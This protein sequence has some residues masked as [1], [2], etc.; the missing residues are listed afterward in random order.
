M[1]LLFAIAA[2]LHGAD[3]IYFGGT[4]L[5]MDAAARTAQ[6]VAVTNGKIEAVGTDA[7]VQ[8]LAGL[9]TRRVDLAGRTLLPGF[10]AAHDHFPHAGYV[11]LYHVDLNSPPIGMMKSMD[12]IVTA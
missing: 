11:G 1:I 4:V 10:Y 3:T 2:L 9:K 6:A 5:T 8:K 12:D 7:E